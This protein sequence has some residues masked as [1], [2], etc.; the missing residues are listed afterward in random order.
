MTG[1]QIA[2]FE[3]VGKLGEGG[4]GVVYEA[5]D[6][7]LD[8]HV[9]LKILPPD[10]VAKPTRLQRFIQEAKAASALNHP[11][12]ITIY[13]IASAD[14]VEYIA[15][16]LVPG[17]TL[18]D[19]LAHR[20]LKVPEALK[21]AVQIAGALA[22]AHAAGIVHRDLKP[23]NIM[24]TDSGL[25]K[26]LDF[27]LAKL[28]DESEVMEDDATRT[29]RALTEHGMIMGSAAYMSPEQAEGR[30]VDARSDIFSFGLVLYEM[31]SGKRAFR[32]DTR[33]ATMAAVLNQ[34][35]P[36]LAEIAPGLPKELERIVARCLRKDLSRRSQS[37]AEIRIA[38][39]ELKE[40]TESGASQVAR[41]GPEGAPP[42]NRLLLWLALAGAVLVLSG[43]LFLLVPRWRE[44]PIPL[45]EVPLTSYP[46]YQGDPTLSPDGSQFAFVWDG[47]QENAMLQLYVS[48][49]GRG[50]P[51][52]LTNT[53]GAGA[54]YP[55]WSPDG[56]SIAFVRFIPGQPNALIVIPALGGPERKIDD[57]LIQDHLAW[58]PDGKWLYFSATVSPQHNALFVE[59]SAGGERRKLT[60]PPAGAYGDF[61]PS[62]SPDGRQLVFTREIADH[63]FDLF[64]AD[65]HGGNTAGA[66]RRITNDHQTK[67]SPVW[68]ADGKDIVYI[69]GEPTSFL[70]MYR[71]PAS[72]GSPVRMEGIGDYAVDLAIAP[73]GH[74]LIYSRSIRDYNI[75]RMPLPASEPRASVPA[76]EPRASASGLAASASAVPT[77][78]LSSTRYETSPSY[79]P[80]GK[81]IVFSSNRG[82]VRQIWVADADGSNPVALTNF[83]EGVA[84]SPKW[85]PD[86]QTIVF[87]ARP[88][89]LADI[90]SIKADGGTPKR[91]TDNP[92]EDHLPC[93]SADGRWIYFASTRSGARQLYRIP[94]NGGEAVQ[95]THKGAYVSMASPDGKWIYYSKPGFAIWRVP[96]D[97]GEE[98]QV[99]PDRSLPNTFAF[100]VTPSGIY[101]IGPRDPASGTLPL[102]LYRF[103]DGQTV[104]L[105]RL[106]TPPNL[107]INVSPDEKWLLYTQLDS[108]VDDLMLVE[109]FR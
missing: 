84:G 47:G 39:E 103:A 99:L 6:R 82:G 3:I 14:G 49:A 78:F 96:A 86:S 35:P 28:T 53:P 58:S 107:H 95:I 89:G 4:M 15:M 63:N 73:K 27:G 16:E 60:D 42:A 68:T 109:N 17:R 85:S 76:S 1:K 37:M 26:V 22:A 74:R 24:I 32:A 61:D 92:A 101:F 64:V 70:A 33:M 79:S 87:D 80:D 13:D 38:L 108:S 5:I 46:S 40:E 106:N 104:D 20:R 48:L 44:T 52:K 30:K 11:N 102:K 51:L 19:L 105:G 8:R 72:G 9:A 55:A 25:V 12:I 41:A 54:V 75:W 2:H 93:Y 90:Y 18:E 98:T 67:R 56:Q 21:Y 94:A 29:E 91:L 7:H 69:A 31:L 81:R 43:A 57:R 50:T 34:E 66:P 77:K 23:A 97:G 62:V 71:V 10:K 83:T 65:L 45:K 88:E 59:P 36:P 100:C